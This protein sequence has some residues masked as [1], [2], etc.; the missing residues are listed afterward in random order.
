MNALAVQTPWL[1]CKTLDPVWQTPYARYTDEEL[2]QYYRDRRGVQY[3]SVLD[4]E[5]TSRDRI[6]AILDNTFTFNHETYRLTEPL[7]WSVNPSADLEWHVLLHKFYYA[8]GLGLAYHLSGNRR[9]LDRWVALTD[10][11]IGQAP[12]DFCANPE[13]RIECS[14]VTGRRIQNWIYAYYYFTKHKPPVLIPADFHRRFL[15][16]LHQQVEY[17][18]AHLSP[19]RNH[20]TLELYAIFLAAVVFPEFRAAG[21]WLQLAR[22][23]IVRNIQTDLLADGVHCELSTDYHHLVLK[24]YLC[25]RRLAQLNAID[26]APIVDERLL[27]A[28][29]FSLHAHKPD[30]IVPALSDG[31]ARS[32]LNLLRQGYEL[33]GREDFLYVATQSA[34]GAPPKQRS[35][36]F[37]QGGYSI[38]RSGWGE[39]EPFTDERYLV[40]DCGP[41]GAGNH[42]HLDALSVEVAA[43]GRSLIV[44]PGRYTYQENTKDIINWRARFRGTVYHNT[45]LVDGRNQ[46]RYGPRPGINR[47]KIQG[48]APQHDLRSFVST[49]DF[50]YLHGVARS[51]EYD[52]VHDRRIFFA[53]PDYWIIIDTLRASRTHKY[54][55]LFHLSEHAQNR[56]DVRTERA[57]RLVYSPHLLLA[58]PA[59]AGIEPRIDSAYVA[60]RYGH[61]LPA[62]VVKFRQQARNALFCTVVYPYKARAPILR[63]NELLVHKGAGAPLEHAYGLSIEIEKND[64]Y[65]IDYCAFAESTGPWFLG[66]HQCEGA[67]FFRREDRHGKAIR[68]YGTRR[69]KKAKR[70]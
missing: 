28:L 32:Y 66:P 37:P 17:L 23:E 41:L 25:V 65:W 10:S 33:Y 64:A 61:K 7:N 36:S 21:D 53:S 50:D 44:D 31:D 54:E 16:S 55:L 22:R 1:A 56:V 42:G 5:E 40:F 15:R 59:V 29:E 24:N 27:K 67:Y 2:L 18:C 8:V 11:W 12:A 45:V 49:T 43:Y 46:T 14:Q 34:R 47:F 62:P 70:C 26:L 6:D 9:Y 69:S 58:Q 68:Q 30:G 4:P 52:A 19:A 3:F 60:Y 39:S 13:L 63:L 57:T 38:L 35:M 51:H 20:R 48:P